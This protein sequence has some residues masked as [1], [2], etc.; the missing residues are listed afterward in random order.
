[1]VASEDQKEEFVE[2]LHEA[3]PW[4]NTRRAGANVKK[5]ELVVEKGTWLNSSHI[6][7]LA[8]L[9]KASIKVFQKPRI[10]I[11]ATGDELIGLEEKLTQGKLYSSNSYALYSQVRKF[12]GIPVNLGVAKDDPAQLEEKIK[13]GLECDMII[14]SGGVSVGD[15][16]FVKPVL[17]KMGM[18]VKFWK[19]AMKPG[20]PVLFGVLDNIPVFGL[21]G[22]PVSC[23]VNFEIFAGPA[24]LKILGGKEAIRKE[25]EAVLCDTLTK[26]KDLRYFVRAKTIWNDGG[27]ITRTTGPQGSGILKSMVQANSFIVMPEEVECI[28]K[29]SKVKVRFLE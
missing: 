15:Y 16:D 19:V 6:G 5:D 8:S 25:V 3:K 27:Y 10:A 4:E 20:K 11:L 29:G 17:E 9:G 18:D 23:M 14:T 12:G 1:M 28:E 7:M 13:E 26:R 22:N 2:I 21:P 24:I